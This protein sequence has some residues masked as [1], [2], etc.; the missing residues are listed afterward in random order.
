MDTKQTWFMAII[1]TLALPALSIYAWQTTTIYTEET[2]LRIATEFL[3]NGPTYSWDGMDDSIQV[4]DVVKTLSMNPEWLVTLQF[5]SSH[6]GYGDRS[7]QVV[8]TVITDHVIKVTV[9]GDTV[10]SAVIDQIWDEIK[11]KKID[12]GD[13]SYT[14]AKELAIEFLK[15]GPT[16]SFDGIEESIQVLDIIA[17]E[18]YP[19]QYIIILS[20]KCSHAGYG[21][22][23]GEALAQVITPHEIRIALSAGVI[24]SAIIDD[25]WDELIQRPVTVVKIISPDRAKEIAVEYVKQE[26]HELNDVSIPHEWAVANLTPEELVGF[27]ELEFTGNGWKVKVSYPVVLKPVYDVF[28]EYNHSIGF[29]WE[30]QLDHE[31]N[32]LHLSSFI[33][34][35]MSFLLPVY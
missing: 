2:A 16:F 24:S 3:E 33:Y 5:T 15:N 12:P 23:T 34:L 19:V 22:R 26:Y 10:T 6:A 20:F 27:T 25:Q 18:S 11:E 35:D 32:I 4:I 14:E 8:A 29:T 13:T 21:D 30:G 1:V 17:M 7:G 28:V 9:N 31:G